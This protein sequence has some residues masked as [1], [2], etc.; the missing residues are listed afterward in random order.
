[1][2]I[3]SSSEN[4]IKKWSNST[5]TTVIKYPIKGMSVSRP[6]VANVFDKIQKTANGVNDIIILTSSLITS[7]KSWTYFMKVFIF[8]FI[9]DADIP[10]K[11]EKINKWIIF[12]STIDLKILLG[13]KLFSLCISFTLISLFKSVTRTGSYDIS[14]AN[15][16]P[17]D[18]AM[19]VVTRYKDIVLIPNLE[20]ETSSDNDTIPQTIEK[21]IRGIMINFSAERNRWDTRSRPLIII[22]WVL[23]WLISIKFINTPKIIPKT[24]DTMIFLVNDINYL[25]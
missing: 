7:L 5:A 21:N 23:D 11:I 22:E 13:K 16:K 15:N 20:I 19:T 8:S 14:E 6:C 3:F 24:I 1:M 10:I 2:K 18:I 9:L 12:P 25:K 17:S 4:V